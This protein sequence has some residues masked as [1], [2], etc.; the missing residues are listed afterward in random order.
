ME[1]VTLNQ[2][3]TTKKNIKLKTRMVES[4]DI[5]QLI[6]IVNWAYRGKQG[7][8]SWTTEEDLVA[9]LRVTREMIEKDMAKSDQVTQIMIVE[10]IPDEADGADGADD[11]IQNEIVGCVKIERNEPTDDNA[12]IGML[13]VNPSFQSMGIGGILMKLGENQLV[14]S[15]NIFKSYLHVI[16]CRPELLTWYRSLGYKEDGVVTPFKVGGATPLRGNL[17]FVHLLKTLE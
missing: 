6:Q 9:G 14:S 15:W 3:I 2:T 8:S 11:T 16:S 4:K 17:E 5:D 13:S 10:K 1:P 7:V 12:V